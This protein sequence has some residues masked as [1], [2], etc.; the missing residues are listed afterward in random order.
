[1]ERE[2]WKRLQSFSLPYFFASHLYTNITLKE[3]PKPLCKSYSLC[4]CRRDMTGQSTVLI[5]EQD[6]VLRDLYVLQTACFVALWK[7]ILFL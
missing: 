5:E 6:F 1:M 7:D 3:N 2:N 4:S